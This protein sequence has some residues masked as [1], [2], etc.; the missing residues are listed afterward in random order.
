MCYTKRHCFKQYFCSKAG[1]IC[2][3][4]EEDPDTSFLECISQEYEKLPPPHIKTKLG[5]IFQD[6]IWGMYKQVNRVPWKT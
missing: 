2:Q 1:S 6:L 4:K 5:K 3:Y